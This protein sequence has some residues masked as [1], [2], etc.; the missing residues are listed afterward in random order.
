MT[1]FK[2]LRETRGKVD[3]PSENRSNVF[4]HTGDEL[5]LAGSLF[6]LQIT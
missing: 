4:A 1:C 3:Q 2:T 6:V 5:C